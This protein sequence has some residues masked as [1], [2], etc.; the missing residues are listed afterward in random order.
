LSKP[1]A[2]SR[3]PI[4]AP[5][6]AMHGVRIATATFRAC[7]W[8]VCFHYFG[9]E[10]LLFVAAA[11]TFV[12]AAKDLTAARVRLANMADPIKRRAAIGKSI[13]LELGLLAVRVV[14]IGLIGAVLPQFNQTVA[15]LV[16]A[17]T[18][19]ALFWARETMVTLARIYQ[20]GPWLRYA[21]LLSSL[22][23][24]A[25]ILLFAE[26]DWDPVAGATTALII[27][28]AVTFA[29]YAVVV[30]IGKL[31]GR[32]ARAAGSV[33]DEADEDET[34]GAAPLIGADG[35]E[36]RSTFKIFIADN[37]VYSWW[38]IVQFG[39]RL[40]A[41]GLLGPFGSIGSRIFFTYRKP[42]AF[43]ERKP[44][45][46]VGRMILIG[47]VLATLLALVAVLAQRSGLL[48]AVGIV[49]VAFVLRIVGLG[50]NLLLWRHFR[51]LITTRD[52]IRP[53]DWLVPR[54][55]LRRRASAAGGDKPPPD[56]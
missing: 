31:S 28:E 46:P 17:L 51:P 18:V 44:R 42:G 34:A 24:L 30:L 50:L 19:C 41:S 56:A 37:V 16:T 13:A 49:A 5:A 20:V 12:L 47:G 9:T 32:E 1:P 38:R 4:D 26:R 8:L 29:G 7:F 15:V 3:K 11:W 54:R 52:K 27:R 39:T 14:I 6:V 10:A 33:G 40:L 53:V 22:T 23:G 2:S 21:T 25:L 48:H 43:V 36:I 35:R 55:T 45:P